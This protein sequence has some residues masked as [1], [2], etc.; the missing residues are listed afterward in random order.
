MIPIPR[1]HQGV[2]VRHPHYE[3]QGPVTRPDYQGNRA[4]VRNPALGSPRIHALSAHR[5][6]RHPRLRGRVLSA[7]RLYYGCGVVS[8]DGVRL[9]ARGGR[10]KQP[11][12]RRRA[13][14]TPSGSATAAIPRNGSDEAPPEGSIGKNLAEPSSREQERVGGWLP[15]QWLTFTLSTRLRRMSRFEQGW[16]ERATR[17]IQKRQ[18]AAKHKRR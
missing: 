8:S 10:C 12:Q 3:P 7:D 2:A 1:A 9:P 17:L 16:H 5:V 15:P 6:D 11:K 4:T 13:A 14:G 18:G